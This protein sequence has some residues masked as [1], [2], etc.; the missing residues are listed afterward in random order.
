MILKK[1]LEAIDMIFGY[2]IPS[3]V[4]RKIRHGKMVLKRCTNIVTAPWKDS[5]NNWE[6]LGINFE[7]LQ[8]A[9]EEEKDNC[10]RFRMFSH[11]VAQQDPALFFH[12]DEEE[13][14]TED[15][16]LVF[17]NSFWDNEKWSDPVFKKKSTRSQ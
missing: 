2:Q 16:K 4:M 13:F 3:W 14:Q 10:R 12:I 7:R 8:D 11:A 17:Q 5:S 9:Q 6:W 15:G 1:W